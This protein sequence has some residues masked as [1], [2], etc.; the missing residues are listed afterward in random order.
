MR[1]LNSIG[2]RF[3]SKNDQNTAK[4]V[5][6][7]VCSIF[8]ASPPE[9]WEKIINMKRIIF[10]VALAML[11]H[12]SMSQTS[13]Q[14]DSTPFATENWG[15]NSAV[16]F[17]QWDHPVPTLVTA[18]PK[19][20]I[21]SGNAKHS[22]PNV[23]VSFENSAF[24]Y[25]SNFSSTTVRISTYDSSEV[26]FLTPGIYRENAGDYEYRVLLDSG[27]TV[28]PWSTVAQFADY[29][30]RPGSFKRGF[31]YLGGYKTSWNHFLLVELRKKG[32]PDILSSSAV[33]W[34][35]TRPSLLHIYTSSQL[36][37]FLARLREPFKIDS[38]SRLPAKLELSSTQDNLVFLLN[39][40]IRD[41]K[42][43]EYQLVKNG[44][45]SREWQSNE[46]DGNFI[47]LKNLL[48]GDYLIRIRY[49]G[50]RQNVLEYPFQIRPAW[51]QTTS[52][53]II[54]GSLIAAF[55][56][57]LILLVR[58]R[59]QKR[60]LLQ[61]KLRNEIAETK[62]RSIRS[63]LNPHF[64]FNALASIQGLM[65]EG[66]LA[67]ANQYF[68]EFSKLLRDSLNENDREFSPL[69]K[70]LELIGIYIRLEQ[71]R[72]RFTYTVGV[73]YGLETNEIEIPYLLIQPLVENAIKHGL[74]HLAGNGVLNI[75]VS[76]E[77]NDLLM[78]IEDNG[79][80]FD[81]LSVGS[82]GHGLRLT[83]DRLRLANLRNR[84]QTIEM[85]I[86]SH[87]VPGGTRVFLT[88]KNWLS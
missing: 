42:S 67:K 45:V 38:P 30:F 18:V 82:G 13:L 31:G 12:A 68:S 19:S 39:G 72:S 87:P 86:E 35:E 3:I 55:F 65:N 43:V 61:E 49:S 75:H 66:E 73:G 50:Q 40:R 4:M 54:L 2:S 51:S 69:R 47:W 15:A 63:Q 41:R 10:L 32:S 26:F 37:E 64:I 21:G 34:E 60:D 33:Y 1:R 56:S 44:V 27:E 84:D 74:A 78:V 28:V 25:R 48:P 59:V 7:H 80:G 22:G 81:P 17:K 20:D 58:F 85:R 23:E 29:D 88:F 62:M 8:R 57:F 14:G 5:Q 83:R 46:F 76:R 52:F 6:I 9:I 53:K 71:L 11:S 24:L 70:E 36:N 77:G 79:D 16:F